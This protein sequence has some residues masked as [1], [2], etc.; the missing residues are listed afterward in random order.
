MKDDSGTGFYDD[1]MFL[2]TLYITGFTYCLAAISAAYAIAVNE[3]TFW[4]TLAMLV[5][6]LFFL[7]TLASCGIGFY[8]LSS[9]AEAPDPR[10]GSLEVHFARMRI[11][12]RGA[13]RGGLILVASFTLFNTFSHAGSY[14]TI[15][16]LVLAVILVLIVIPIWITER[17]LGSA[18]P[19][20]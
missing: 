2:L 13:A 16:A 5:A 7:Y 6:L 15:N 19:Y 18:S 1:R 3:K 8:R 20:R 12:F 11:I 10:A 14:W 17:S 4:L 9:G